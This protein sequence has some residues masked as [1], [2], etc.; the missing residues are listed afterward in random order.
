MQLPTNAGKY[1]ALSTERGRVDICC[2]VGDGA[3]VMGWT[4]RRRP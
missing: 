2:S 1:G 3:F 4:E